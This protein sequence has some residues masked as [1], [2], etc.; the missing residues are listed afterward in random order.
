MKPSSDQSVS[1]LSLRAATVL[2]A[3]LVAAV[4]GSLTP[5]RADT[6]RSAP[7]AEPT[8]SFR[9]EVLFGSTFKIAAARLALEKSQNPA[10][11][12]LAESVIAEQVPLRNELLVNS[13]L[14]P[15]TLPGGAQVPGGTNFTSRDRVAIL[16][17]L[18]DLDAA[19]FDA[20]FGPLMASAY[21]ATLVQFTNY[22]LYGD[23][24]R[25]YVF[26]NRAL[27]KI[28]A[29]YQRVRGAN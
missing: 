22:A 8:P 3:A 2:S 12:Q 18:K 1:R 10:V 11:R 13:H 28:K 9:Q 16:Q 7:L 25:M 5:A 24:G 23:N 20:A 19:G 29:A 17:Q 27:P 21:D 6:V 26:A 4:T 14:L 15:P